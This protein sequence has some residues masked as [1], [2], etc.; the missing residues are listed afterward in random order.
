M[1]KHY[2]IVAAQF[3]VL[4]V[5]FT[6]V[7]CR[8]NNK[9]T[10][11]VDCK[12]LGVTIPAFEKKFPEK[13]VTLDPDYIEEGYSFALYFSSMEEAEYKIVHCVIDYTEPKYTYLAASYDLTKK[14]I[15]SDT[16]SFSYPFD[17]LM[18]RAYFTVVD[19]DDGQVRCYGWHHIEGGSGYSPEFMVQYKDKEGKIYTVYKDDFEKGRPVAPE[20]KYSIYPEKVFRFENDDETYTIIWGY[21]GFATGVTSYGLI[22]FKMDEKGVKPIPLFK[23]DELS[24][25]IDVDFYYNDFEEDAFELIRFDKDELAFYLPEVITGGG[26]YNEIL[27]GRYKKYV[28]NGEAFVLQQQDDEEALQL[29]LSSITNG[30]KETIADLVRYPLHR[31]Y[32]LRDISNKNDMMKHFDILFDDDFRKTIGSLKRDDWQEVGWRGFMVLSGELWED[33]GELV[34]VNYSSPA[35]QRLRDSL[36]KAEFDAL[37]PSLQ[38]DWTPIDRLMLA[39]DVYG[40]ARIDKS[41][42]SETLYRLSLFAKNAEIGDKPVACINGYAQYEGNMGDGYFYFK[43]QDTVASYSFGCEH[44]EGVPVDIWKYLH[45]MDESIPCRGHYYQIDYDF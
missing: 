24:E 21:Y 20:D 25:S 7:L 27:S 9:K 19:S 17:T 33:G 44:E 4:L 8:C 14:V 6:T 40:F 38:G 30:D 15:Q 36:I 32:P 43:S 3:F 31:Q 26:Y 1:K 11:C 5:M 13:K 39:D 16:S 35:E 18:E 23:D 37:Y 34:A 2:L 42:V 41:T 28:W 12:A 45:W 22:A 29:I 10:E